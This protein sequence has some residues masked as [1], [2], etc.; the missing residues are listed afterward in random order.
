MSRKLKLTSKLA[1]IK[2]MYIRS[3]KIAVN[4]GQIFIKYSKKSIRIIF[5]IQKYRPFFIN[6]K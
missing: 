5:L 3:D 2:E 1:I 6:L 4:E